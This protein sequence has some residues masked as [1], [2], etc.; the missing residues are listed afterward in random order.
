MHWKAQQSKH[1]K[2]SLGEHSMPRV[3]EIPIE[4]TPKE[5]HDIYRR[6]SREYGPFANQVKIFAQRTPA[7]L[8]VSTPS[9]V[10]IGFAAENVLSRPTMPV[11]SELHTAH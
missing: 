6:F 4:D 8:S 1:D 3:K 9:S 2:K 7:P 5:V 11:W 10:A